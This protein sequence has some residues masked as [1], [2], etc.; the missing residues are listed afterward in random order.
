MPKK[1]QQLAKLSRPRL[2]EALPR[3]R[4]FAL[5]DEKRRHPVIWIAGPPGA[6][7]T[8]LACS[9]LEDRG[10]RGL[11]YHV[12]AGDNDLS[13]FFFY[14][15]EAARSFPSSQPLPLLTPEYR[16]DLR[17]FARRYFRAL[18]SRLPDDAVVVLDNFQDAEQ[19][20]FRRLITEA[21]TEVPRHATLLIVSRTEPDAEFSE[22]LAREAVYVLGWPELKL[23]FD[24][25]RAIAAARD[26]FDAAS[27]ATLFA[28]SEGWA[29]GLTLMLES[30]R[31]NT[32]APGDVEA[33]SADAVFNYFAAQI[34]DTASA[35]VRETLVS[36]SVFSAFSLSFAERISSNPLAG[37]ML[38]ELC[39]R[40][41]FTFR[42]GAAEPRYQY[43]DLF[44]KFLLQRMQS[45]FGADARRQ[46]MQTAANLL[47]ED[48]ANEEAFPLYVK[49][50]D[51]PM[52]TDLVFRIAPTLLAQGRSRTLHDW[53]QVHGD[54]R[55]QES[56]WLQYWLGNALMQSDLP[57]A[58]EC[59]QKAFECFDAGRDPVGQCLCAAE[60]IRV[61]Y[62]S[63]DDFTLFDKWIVVLH[64]LLNAAPA[65][66]DA[67]SEMKVCSALLLALSARQPGHPRLPELLV[68][69]AALLDEN[70]E[71]NQKVAAGMALF[72]HYTISNQLPEAQRIIEKVSPLL[73]DVGVTA[74]NK[75]YWWLQLGY[76][77][78]RRAAVRDA[79]KA[80]QVAD[81]LTA[82]HGLRQT[83]FVGRCF[84]AFHFAALSDFRSGQAVL[85]GLEHKVTETRPSTGALFHLA[86]CLL[87]LAI[88][89]G[90]D[91]AHHGG[92]ALAS[93]SRV[94]RPFFDVAWHAHAAAASAMAGEYEVSRALIAE[95][96]RRSEGTRLVSYRSNLLMASA[97]SQI[98][99]GLLPAAH[100]SIREMLHI[101]RETGSWHY[102]RSV[103]TV[104]DVVLEE[105]LAA[106]IEVP[107]VQ[108]IV[109]RF[110]MQPRRPDLETWPWPIKIHTLGEFRVEVDGEALSFS[111]KVPKKLLALL[112]AI[113]AF[114]GKSV[115]EKKLVDALWPDEPGDAAH[116]AFAVSLH[117][118][119]KLLIHA[120]AVQ[121]SDGVVALDASRCWVDVWALEQVIAHGE[122]NGAVASTTDRSWQLYRG[123]FCSEDAEASWALSMRERL[124][125]RFLRHVARVARQLEQVGDLIA[126]ISVYQKGIDT[127]DLAEELYQGL[128]RCH[129]Q[130][131]RRAEAM[132]VYRRLR[133]TLSVTLG[134][135][136]SSQSEQ[137]F[138]LLVND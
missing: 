93:A 120:D 134:I 74:L 69:T 94:G 8:T 89:N 52:A 127:D 124:R 35:K 19:A 2:Y 13:T 48:G 59:F 137:L 128:M 100:E 81:K 41:L 27:F 117:R 104:K 17:G 43:H 14:L 113:V 84:R 108:M 39:R 101:G 70:I 23:R 57:K 106:G 66:P 90:A 3:E 60:L 12:D 21:I 76:Y 11:W 72:I 130:L 37:D 55:I 18:F 123:H 30:M 46:L 126:A 20:G 109:R 107:F 136:P 45:M 31:R 32:G 61:Q 36:T 16:P 56:P 122:S 114:G 129:M 135:P 62:Y 5:L 80:W 87:N 4:L 65:F 125:G 132:T 40:Q 99:Q 33:A 131:G 118:L 53:I 82:E 7:K 102:L 138:R 91:A 103:P 68:R 44:R 64:E 54:E 24:E 75:A 78:F 97:Y 77:H 88:G 110:D 73:D 105:A 121:L 51:W 50:G 34:F 25:A 96:W 133:Q 112:K 92:L 119:R 15:T 85:E 86:H 58:G 116:E 79:D 115:P 71:V 95:G 22:H 98:R 47:A 38:D 10:L 111:R 28:G 9:Y 26:H 49:A 1:S 29:A 67:A 6:G 63:Y 42:R 83:D